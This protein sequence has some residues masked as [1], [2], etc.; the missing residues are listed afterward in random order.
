MVRL[1][2]I[3]RVCRP[4]NCIA[5]VQEGFPLYC[6]GPLF[7]LGNDADPSTYSTPMSSNISLKSHYHWKLEQILCPPRVLSQA[8][9]GDCDQRDKQ[10]PRSCDRGNSHSRVNLPEA[11]CNLVA[12]R[13]NCGWSFRHFDRSICDRFLRDAIHSKAAPRSDR[14]CRT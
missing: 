13:R 4:K 2:R 14:R 12:D 8:R 5:E 7:H 6:R 3:D 10:V 11:Y 9:R 1:F